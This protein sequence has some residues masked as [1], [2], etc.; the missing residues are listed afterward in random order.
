MR[1]VIAVDNVVVPVSLA[2]L[3]CR[4]LEPESS[5]P[6]ARFTRVLGQRK[7]AAVIV[8]RPDQVHGLTV[9]RGSEGEVELDGCHGGLVFGFLKGNR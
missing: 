5:F 1:D 3:E 9:G 8:P 4:P 2:L 7:L 6:T